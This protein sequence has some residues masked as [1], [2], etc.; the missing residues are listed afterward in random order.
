MRIFDCHCHIF[1]PKI[2]AN[3]DYYLQK[4]QAF[5]LLY[6]NPKSRLVTA[7][8]L[9]S[10][11]E[12]AA[13][14]KAIV[15]GFPW[16]DEEVFRMHNDYVIESTIKYQGRLYGF[17]CFLPNLK[18]YLTE[19]EVIRCLD[20]GLFGIG[21]IAW[22]MS[23]YDKSVIESLRPAMEIAYERNVPVM[24]HTNEPI[25]HQ[26]PGKTQMTLAGI[27][28]LVI[29][30]SK[31]KLILAHWGGGIFFYQLLKKQIREKYENVWFDT[32]A[33][34]YLYTNLIYRF[35]VNIVGMHKI[36]FGSDYPLLPASRY[37]K[38][39][40]ESGLREEEKEAILWSNT[41]KILKLEVNK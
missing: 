25:G 1:P 34:P 37:I 6:G 17:C 22:Y 35:A 11:M 5:N 31:N 14:N 19:R 32:A 13:V 39:I 38:E 26:Y 18:S 20:A 30:F 9:I 7:D 41:H 21:E 33:S 2:I 40:E 8:E 4:D 27:N 15:F 28:N 29:S 24:F 16:E 3:R 12:S 23:D 10:H 36:L